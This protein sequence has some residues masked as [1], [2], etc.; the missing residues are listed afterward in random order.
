M[1]N[2][3]LVNKDNKIKGVLKMKNN[4][5]FYLLYHILICLSR[6]LDYNAYN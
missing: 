6:L 1:T 2:T 3:I 5:S 4:D